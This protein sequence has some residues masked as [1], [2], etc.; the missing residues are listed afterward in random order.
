[1]KRAVK[2]RAVSLAALEK[3]AAALLNA[4]TLAERAAAAAVTGALRVRVSHDIPG[5]VV[6][7]EAVKAMEKVMRREG[8][9]LSWEIRVLDSKAS[10][11]GDA[12]TIMEP[13]IRWDDAK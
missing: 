12:L 5:D 11:T 1:M 4:D 8:F 9:K 7:T 10:P 6:S 13:V 2:L 3:Q